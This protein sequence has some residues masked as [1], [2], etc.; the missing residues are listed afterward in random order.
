MFAELVKER[1]LNEPEK[2]DS[3]EKLTGRIKLFQEI[4]AAGLRELGR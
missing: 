3:H 2:G 4:I 1:G